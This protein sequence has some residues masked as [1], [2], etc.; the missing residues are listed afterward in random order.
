MHN[1]YNS[2]PRNCCNI[3]RD[4]NLDSEPQKVHRSND[5]KG[6][7][8]AD[9]L[10]VSGGGGCPPPEHYRCILSGPPCGAVG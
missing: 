4:K 9:L 2:I 7:L 8:L 5:Q 3:S 10:G 1:L 6:G